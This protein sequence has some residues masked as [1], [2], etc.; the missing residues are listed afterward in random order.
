MMV[1]KQITNICL[2]LAVA[3]IFISFAIIE[4]V[5]VIA[6]AG[7]AMAGY[8]ALGSV[9]TL[10]T[11][12]TGDYIAIN[13][14]CTGNTSAGYRRQNLITSFETDELSF[15]L[16]FVKSPQFKF[17]QGRL[18]TLYF[19]S[20]LEDVEELSMST[21]TAHYFGHDELVMKNISDEEETSASEPRCEEEETENE[22]GEKYNGK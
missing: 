21:L 16:K 19:H 9:K 7:I 3:I 8:I 17:K 12:K 15:D 14:I 10:L 1:R 11:L 13:A 18:Y 4:G 6:L 2:A 22:G 20:K 5:P